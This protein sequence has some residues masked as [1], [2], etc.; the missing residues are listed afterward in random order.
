MRSFGMFTNRAAQAGALYCAVVFGAGFVLGVVRTT[1]I[2]PL[3]GELAAV[4]LEAPVLLAIAWSACGSIVER[5]D[6][7]EEFMDRL[8]MGGVAL[9]MLVCAE[10]AAAFLADGHS[11][12]SFSHLHGRSAIL[13]GLLAQLAFAVFPLLNRRFGGS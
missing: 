5:F 2:A 12:S 11:L 13:L 3:S 4:L 10:A 8:M 1:W 7:S 6:V 9:V